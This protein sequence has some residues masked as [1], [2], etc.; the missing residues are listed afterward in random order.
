MFFADLK[1]EV[2]EWIICG[3]SQVGDGENQDESEVSVF[4]DIVPAAGKIIKSMEKEIHEGRGCKDGNKK[5][6]YRLFCHVIFDGDRH[7]FRNIKVEHSRDEA[8]SFVNGICPK[9]GPADD[10][11]EDGIKVTQEIK[12]SMIQSAESQKSFGYDKAAMP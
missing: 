2:D 3:S 7:D 1:S 5:N 11:G 10:E 8:Q 9:K 12:T 6:D 4:Q